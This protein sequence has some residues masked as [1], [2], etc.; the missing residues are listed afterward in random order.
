MKTT[1]LSAVYFLLGLLYIVL[2]NHSSFCT[3]L[4]IKSLI[5]PV[6]IIIFIINL[7]KDMTR[8]SGIMLAGL[9]FSWAGDVVIDFSFMAGLACFLTTHIIYLTAFFITPGENRIFHDR[10]YLL[11]PVIIYGTGLIWFLYADLNGMRFP[12]ILYALVILTMLSAAINRENKVNRISFWLV[13]AGAVLF[14]ISD[15]A[16][17]VNKF[18]WPVKYS[19][20]IIMLTYMAAQYLITTGF[21]KQIR[22]KMNFI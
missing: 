7:R 6:V 4:A 12:V 17:A 3:E 1:I 9:F 2:E 11:L 16:I 22:G 8:L 14:V 15:S 20:L 5:V 18:S 19:R 13:L 21:I 10:F